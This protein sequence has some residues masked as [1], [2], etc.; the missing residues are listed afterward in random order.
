MSLFQ[1][2]HLHIPKEKRTVQETFILTKC[3]MCH[4]IIFEIATHTS[5]GPLQQNIRLLMVHLKL[6][7]A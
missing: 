1:S 7:L 3:P 2:H 6:L 4:C 5:G